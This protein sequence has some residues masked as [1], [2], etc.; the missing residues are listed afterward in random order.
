MSNK[1]SVATF[2]EAPGAY[3]QPPKPPTLE[4]KVRTPKSNATLIF[5]NANFF[6]SW[7]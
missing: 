2:P 3:G 4:S 1:D 6:V 5:S 7:K